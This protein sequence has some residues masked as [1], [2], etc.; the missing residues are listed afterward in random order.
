MW[1]VLVDLYFGMYTKKKKHSV[2]HDA[3]TS[4]SKSCV[5]QYF[6]CWLFDTVTAFL[7]DKERCVCARICQCKRVP[8]RV[9]ASVSECIVL[10]CWQQVGVCDKISEPADTRTARHD[11][12]SASQGFIT[13]FTP[14]Q[15]KGARSARAHARPAGTAPSSRRVRAWCAV[16]TA[17]GPSSSSSD[18]MWSLCTH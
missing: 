17:R 18:S 3:D 8:G 1:F 4:H 14:A 13:S 9:W 7:H 12:T 11:F 2:K 10:S 15:T 5:S 6:F 16:H